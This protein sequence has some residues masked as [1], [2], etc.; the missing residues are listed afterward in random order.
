MK[1]STQ[2]EYG[3]RAMVNLARS[4]PDIKNIQTISQEENI[5]AKYLEKIMGKL[6]AKNLV[7]STQGKNGGYVLSDHPKNITA[8]EI[9]ETLESL[10][11]K[12]YDS[13]CQKKKNCSSSFVWIKL[14]VQIKRTLDGIKLS[15]LIK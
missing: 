9:I 6:R 13:H 7:I 10:A 11:I 12:C 14:G 2:A 1:F 4:H 15:Q 3:L 5:S 8:G